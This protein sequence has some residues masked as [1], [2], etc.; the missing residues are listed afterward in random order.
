M[1]EVKIVREEVGYKVIVNG[2]VVGMFDEF[3]VERRIDIGVMLICLRCDKVGDYGMWDGSLE[4]I[5]DNKLNGVEII[6]EVVIDK[7]KVCGVL[8]SVAVS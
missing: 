1:D 5:E 2:K 3:V 8:I 4:N 6:S 7:V